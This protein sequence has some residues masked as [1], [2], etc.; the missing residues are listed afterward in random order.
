MRSLIRDR[1]VLLISHRFSSVRSADNVY[2][3]DHG[4]II[5]SG[6]HDELMR[7]NGQYAELFTMQAAAYQLA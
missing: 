3:L 1:T 6:S 2:V 7:L 4:R 5:E